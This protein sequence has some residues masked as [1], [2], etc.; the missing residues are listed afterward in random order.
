MYQIRWGTSGTPGGT[1]GNPIALCLTS[2]VLWLL[3]QLLL[4]PVLQGKG[5]TFGYHGLQPF[6]EKL[7]VIENGKIRQARNSTA[8]Q[9]SRPVTCLPNDVY[10]K[11]HSNTA[12]EWHHSSKSACKCTSESTQAY[13]ALK[14]MMLTCTECQCR[15]SQPINP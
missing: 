9:P 2:A 11:L 14:S 13:L 7:G 10:S 4:L 6:P 3:L 12:D 8:V 5:V 15:V 1:I